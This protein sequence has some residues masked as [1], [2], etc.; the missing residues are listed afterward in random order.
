MGERLGRESNCGFI[1]QQ[2]IATQKELGG[3]GSLTIFDASEEWKQEQK[4]RRIGLET[5]LREYQQQLSS[6]N[7]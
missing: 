4:Q 2:I 5:R 3:T 6:C 7:R 1:H